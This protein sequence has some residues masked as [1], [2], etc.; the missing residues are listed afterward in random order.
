[1]AAAADVEEEE[2]PTYSMDPSGLPKGWELDFGM[3]KEGYNMCSYGERNTED[4][5]ARAFQHHPPSDPVLDRIDDAEPMELS[6]AY[7]NVRGQ[8][9]LV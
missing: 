3:N 2:E 4:T 5:V 7:E 6:D 1:M 9:K 8:V